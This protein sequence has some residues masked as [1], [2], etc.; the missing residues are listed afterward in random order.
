MNAGTLFAGVLFGSIGM[1]YMIYG[2]KQQKFMVILSGL[3]LC[4]VP[5]FISNLCF[6]YLICLAITSSSL[7]FQGLIA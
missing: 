5:Y 3:A 7:H 2:K 1:A 6:L 4:A